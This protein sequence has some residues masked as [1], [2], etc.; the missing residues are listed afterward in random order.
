[1]ELVSVL[2]PIYNE[3]AFVKEIVQRVLAVDLSNIGYE[4]EIVIV[5]DGSTDGTAQELT[6]IQKKNKNIL[7]MQHEKNKGKGAAIRTAIMNAKGNIIL[8]QD[9]DLEYDP[10]EYKDLLLPFSKKEVNVVYG[11][12]YI[13]NSAKQQT[14]MKLKYKKGYRLAYLGGRVLTTVTNVLYGANLSDEATGY[15]VFRA[16]VLKN[17]SLKCTKFEF[18][19]EV[20]AKVLKAGY[21]IV[22]VPISYNP[23]TYEEGKKINYKDG[24]EAIWTL[25][26]YKFQN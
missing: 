3:K 25:I 18:C 23:R 26:K 12:R 17:I 19:P 8:I 1:M 24:F 13:F 10:Q 16:S 4:K 7:L 2:M 14:N 9:A 20:T 5:D 6:Q 22:E 21:K 15:K 11:T